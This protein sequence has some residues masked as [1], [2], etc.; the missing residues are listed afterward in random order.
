MSP[1]EEFR[2]ALKKI[3]EKYYSHIM[4]KHFKEEFSFDYTTF[5]NA[6][7]GNRSLSKKNFDKLIAALQKKPEVSK[8]EIEVLKSQFHRVQQEKNSLNEITEKEKLSYLPI[9]RSVFRY[10]LL[11][12]VGVTFITIVFLIYT[13]NSELPNWIPVYADFNGITMAKVS[14]GCFTMGNLQGRENEKPITHEC[15]ENSF[16]IGKTE[17]TSSQ[18]GSPPD[19][20]CNTNQVDKINLVN[21]IEDNYPR[22]CVTWQEALEFCRSKGLRLPTEREWEYAARGPNSSLYP[23]GNDPNPA[24]AILRTDVN[25][26]AKHG[27]MLPVGSKPQDVSWIGAYDMAGS[28]REFTSTIYDTVTLDGQLRFSYPYNSEDGRESLE[29]TGTSFDEDNR[30]QDTTL[31]VVRGGGFD[32]TIDRASTTVRTYEFFD[33]RWNEYGFRCATDA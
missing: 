17:V 16:W 25:D 12:L 8:E 14:P 11:G 9:K 10:F 24:Y 4:Q 22:N 31:R 18:Y 15:F 2:E 32:K 28:L 6:V 23:W 26:P 7:S 30:S 20:N 19:K 21:G 3:R 5:Y 29:N 27:Q 33:F 1:E 13:T